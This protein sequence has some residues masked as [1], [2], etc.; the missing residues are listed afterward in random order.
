MFTM[1]DLFTIQDFY[2]TRFDFKGLNVYF[3]RLD[4]TIILN[5]YF[6]RFDFSTAL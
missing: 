4:F 6:T 5:A 3:T 1:Q 2:Y